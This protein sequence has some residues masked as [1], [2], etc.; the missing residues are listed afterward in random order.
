AAEELEE[1]LEI[2]QRWKPGTKEWEEGAELHREEEY[3]EAL[4]RLESLVVSRI[5]EL[6]RQGQA[7]TGYKLRQHISKALTTRQQAIKA[8]LEHYNDL[9]SE[10]K[11]TRPTFDAQEIMECAYMGEFDI[12][13]LSR[14]GILNKPWTKPAV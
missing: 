14:R 1:K 12:L 11:P 13:R 7:G 4:D 2:S 10:F 8:A 3:L 6:A 9:A 5:F